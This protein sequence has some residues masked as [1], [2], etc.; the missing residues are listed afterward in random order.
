MAGTACGTAPPVDVA[1]A[2]PDAF[3]DETA[4]LTDA[5][6]ELKLDA[7]EPVALAAAELREDARDERDES[8]EDCPL[9]M[10]ER[11][12]DPWLRAEDAA[13]APGLVV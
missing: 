8:A 5:R 6:A 7:A 9:K 3:T 11:I 2:E 13:E 10:E 1:A 12:E 4:L